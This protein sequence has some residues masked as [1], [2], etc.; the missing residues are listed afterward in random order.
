M[1]HMVQKEVG[2]VG[3]D[4]GHMEV[5]VENR[6]VSVVEVHVEDMT[7]RHMVVVLE[8]H[9]EIHHSHWIDMHHRMALLHSALVEVFA[10]RIDHKHMAP[11]TFGYPI[12]DTHLHCSSHHLQQSCNHTHSQNENSW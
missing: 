12:L 2:M 11:P 7:H 9:K 5:F 3:K 10:K 4:H 6:L 1:A 8:S